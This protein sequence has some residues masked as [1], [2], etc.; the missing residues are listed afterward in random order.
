MPYSLI[1]VVAQNPILGEVGYTILDGVSVRPVSIVM[2]SPLGASSAV[3][4]V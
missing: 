1:V 3:Y 2:L 4:V